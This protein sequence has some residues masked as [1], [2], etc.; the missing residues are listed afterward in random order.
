MLQED[1]PLETIA[2]ITGI[3]ISEVEGFANGQ[4]QSLQGE[5]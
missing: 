1:I 3:A 2:R 5:G 4:L